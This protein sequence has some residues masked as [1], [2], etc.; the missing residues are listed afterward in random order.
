MRHI[1]GSFEF[2]NVLDNGPVENGVIEHGTDEQKE[3]RWNLEAQM[4]GLGLLPIY[5][6]STVMKWCEENKGK[7]F[8]ECVTAS[9]RAYLLMG[10]L[11]KRDRVEEEWEIIQGLKNED[12]KKQYTRFKKSS[13][14]VSKSVADR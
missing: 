10:M 3:K 2:F 14:S 9:C 6:K 1:T 12:D 13:K 4:F 8:L 7:R 5:G 11:D